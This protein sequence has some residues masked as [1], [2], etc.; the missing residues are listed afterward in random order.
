MQNLFDNN[1]HVA[2]TNNMHWKHIWDTNYWKMLPSKYNLYDIHSF[3]GS[4]F[5]CWHIYL[6]VKY[7]FNAWHSCRA[8]EWTNFAQFSLL[9]CHMQFFYMKVVCFQHILLSREEKKN[10]GD[11]MSLIKRRNAPIHF[12][13]PS[14][15]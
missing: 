12:M 15:I 9:T 2:H 1:S 7:V 14:Q 11:V 3:I 13:P 6:C 4:N 8:Y 10:V 5:I